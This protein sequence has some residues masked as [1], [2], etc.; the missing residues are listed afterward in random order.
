MFYPVRQVPKLFPLESRREGGG[1]ESEGRR[2]KP[3]SSYLSPFFP[4]CFS[5][6]PDLQLA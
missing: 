1:R 2:R 6:T 4:N 5:L 3:D